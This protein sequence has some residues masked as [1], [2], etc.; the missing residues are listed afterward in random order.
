MESNQAVRTRVRNHLVGSVQQLF[1]SYMRDT[2]ITPDQAYQWFRTDTQHAL[3]I[4]DTIYGSFVRVRPERDLADMTPDLTD[5]PALMT[6]TTG[7]EAT[8]LQHSSRV[9]TSI[10]DLA[11]SNP[12]LHIDTGIACVMGAEGMLLPQT[13]GGPSSLLLEGIMQ[14]VRR[15]YEEQ[16]DDDE[17]E[18]VSVVSLLL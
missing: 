2:Q 1:C 11:R 15:E 5:R 8:L 17:E 7:I 10:C 14:D 18:D 3:S 13:I 6:S 16:S 12:Q 9:D 4:C